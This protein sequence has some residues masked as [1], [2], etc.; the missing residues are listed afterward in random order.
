MPLCK[1]VEDG[2]VANGPVCISGISQTS[3]HILAG[4]V[5]QHAL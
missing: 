2:V 5:T 4:T 1:V 3:T